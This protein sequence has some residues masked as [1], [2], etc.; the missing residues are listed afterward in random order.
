[1]WNFYARCV[2]CRKEK[3]FVR[4]RTYKISRAII[5]KNPHLSPLNGMKSA[6]ELC[7]ACYKNIK[8]ATGI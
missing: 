5:E 3:F 8:K 4:T 1:M 2:A 6:G 7:T